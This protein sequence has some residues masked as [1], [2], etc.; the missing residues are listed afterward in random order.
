MEKGSVC[1]NRALTIWV[2]SQECSSSQGIQ[3]AL[4][5]AEYGHYVG[6]DLLE[7]FLMEI[8]ICHRVQLDENVATIEE[9]L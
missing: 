9:V 2:P 3:F 6:L 4:S 5:S 7:V 1:H 8:E